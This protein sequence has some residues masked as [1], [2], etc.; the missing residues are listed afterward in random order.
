MEQHPLNVAK[1]GERS[2]IPVADSNI[3]ENLFKAE[4]PPKGFNPLQASNKDLFRYGYPP[5]P[6]KETNP[7]YYAKWEKHLSRPIRF[8]KP[9]LK[10]GP[11]NLK[12]NFRKPDSTQ[13][14]DANSSNYNWSGAVLTN[15]PS[16]QYFDSVSASWIVP[17]A[18]PP[19]SA[20]NGK[21]YND[22]HWQVRHYPETGSQRI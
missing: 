16:G 17:T 9:T 8:I 5:R 3:V 2:E 19:D 21:T 12:T 7:L 11:T 4:T 15:P 10:R 6:N 20:W 18:W 1:P 22:G 14:G 13:R